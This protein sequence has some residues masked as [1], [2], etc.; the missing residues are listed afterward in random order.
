MSLTDAGDIYRFYFASYGQEAEQQKSIVHVQFHSQLKQ[1][2]AALK[3]F[4]HSAFSKYGLCS[5]DIPQ[6]KSGGWR[7]TAFVRFDEEP[8][9]AAMAATSAV[10][11]VTSVLSDDGSLIRVMCQFAREL[12]PRLSSVHHPKGRDPRANGKLFGGQGGSASR[13][14]M[15]LDDDDDHVAVT[16][17]SPSL[18]PQAS[19]EAACLSHERKHGGTFGAARRH[20]SSQYSVAGHHF[21]SAAHAMGRHGD[22][23]EMGSLGCRNEQQSMLAMPVVMTN[24]GGYFAGREMP[25]SFQVPFAPQMFAT[26]SFGQQYPTA[27]VYGAQTGGG[28]HGLY[29]PVISPRLSPM[30]M[31][32]IGIESIQVDIQ[33]EKQPL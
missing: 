27:G 30:R 25:P 22:A 10:Q 11:N 31:E 20:G 29:V 1:P 2:P 14:D 9:L 6:R 21:Q 13:R 16:I 8:V 26:Q 5:V 28:H 18:H 15:S 12:I 3:E 4:L 17:Q 7:R 23:D 24:M 33:A 32:S 19:N